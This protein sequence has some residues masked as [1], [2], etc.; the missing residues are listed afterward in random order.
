LTIITADYILKCDEE[1]TILKDQAICFDE[2]IIDIASLEKLSET[3]P[4]A[5]I[6]RCKPNSVLLPGLINPHLHLEFS[7]NKTTLK[8]GDF[9]SWLNSV[10][11]HREELSLKCQ[12]E[13]MDEALSDVLKSGTTTVGAVSSFGLDLPSCVKSPLNIIYFNEVLG[14]NPAAVDALYTDFLGRVEESKRFESESFTPAV[15]IHSPYST[16]PILA[17]AALKFAKSCDMLVSTHFMESQAERDWLDDGSGDFKE[18]FKNFSPEA[19]PINE[20]LSYLELFKEQNTLFTHA[21][22]AT[23][24]EFEMMNDL[25]VITH[26][27]VSN[28]LLGNGKLDIKKVKNLTIA[29]DGLSSNS[30]LSLWD[31]MR[32]GLMMHFDEDVNELAGRFLTAVTANGAKALKRDTGVLQKTKDA[33]IISVSL[34]QKLENIEDIALFLILSVKNVDRLF[35]K[36]EEII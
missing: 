3:F 28:R 17:K 23:D 26:C 1:F 16:H 12:Q 36:G 21:T 8:Y 24:K 32:A 29:T 22:K 27:P 33:D 4:K 10:I 31:E 18:F 19:K 35:I 2:K 7:A 25:G 20:A 30:S 15:S 9:I 13:C 5:K 14:S 6:I 34:S 11:E